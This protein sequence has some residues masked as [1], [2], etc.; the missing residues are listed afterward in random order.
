MP[1]WLRRFTFNK[2][3]EHFDEINSQSSGTSSKSVDK[4]KSTIKQFQPP[5]HTPPKSSSK[6]KPPGFTTSVKKPS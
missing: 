6:P 3:Q 2:I 1:L 4:I 5:S